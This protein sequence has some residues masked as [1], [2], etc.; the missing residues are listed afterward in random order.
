MLWV[1]DHSSCFTTCAHRGRCPVL[2]LCGKLGLRETVQLHC[3]VHAGMR[4]PRRQT[5]SPEGAFHRSGSS[6]L[7]ICCQ[8]VANVL[9]MCW[10]RP[11]IGPEGT[12]R[13]LHK[14]PKNVV[15]YSKDVKK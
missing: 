9:L 6:V 3:A 7:I 11:S 14:Y 12:R 1:P 2:R 5:I 10:L 13:S 15:K 4:A 8:C